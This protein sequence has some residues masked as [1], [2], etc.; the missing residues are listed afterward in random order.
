MIIDKDYY[1]SHIKDGEK[2]IKM[3]RILDKI[4]IV[5]NKHIV[6]STDFLDPYEVYL[7]KSILNR[8]DEINYIDYGGYNNS[9]RKM[10]LISPSYMFLD[11]IE[12]SLSCIKVE[13]DLVTLSHK[14]YLGAL[15]NLGIKREKVG[16][17]LVHKDYGYIIV[18]DEIGNYVLYNL[19]KIGNKNVSTTNTTFTDLEIPSVEYKEIKRFLTSLRIDLVI[20]EAF[21][22]SRKD[23]MDIIKRGF[24]KINW[25]PIDKPAKEVSEGDVVSVRGYGRFILYSIEGLSRKGRVM[26][27]IRILI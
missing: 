8:F 21:N 14:D 3:R 18:K 15:L 7:A 12:D 11:H 16:D 26:G 10:I 5:L 23:S 25:E 19:E 2:L 4:E 22:L 20:S 1:T 24:V 27:N 13:G 6:Q 17:I 9:E